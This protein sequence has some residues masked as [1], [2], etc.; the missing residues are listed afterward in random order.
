[1]TAMHDLTGQL[2]IAAPTLDDAHFRRSVVLICHYDAE[3]CMGLIINKPGKLTLAAMLE[4]L[5]VEIQDSQRQL[6]E[7][8]PIHDGGPVDPMRGFI[9]HD[10]AHRFERT[11]RIDDALHLSASPD[12]LHALAQG[13]GPR[14]FLA[15]LGYA[16]WAPGQLEQELLA[17]DWL[18]A[19][20]TLAL[21]FQQDASTCWTSALHSIGVD[22]GHWSDQC[23]HA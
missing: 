2:L 14:H 7:R 10:A 21:I 13:Q 12:V 4:D 8:I 17:G 3:G 6:L 23:G 19:P 15:L 11:M 16:A 20:S 22:P 18:I 1:M 9:L 5:G